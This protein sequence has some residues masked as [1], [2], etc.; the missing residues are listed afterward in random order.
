M[1]DDR[2]PKEI[3]YDERV[4]E[5]MRQ[6][7][8]I[9]KE[10]GISFITSFALDGELTCDTIVLEPDATP[11]LRLIATMLNA[12]IAGVFHGQPSGTAQEIGHA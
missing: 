4:H 11:K 7:I 2:G 8:E 3:A 6:I 9:C 5:L 1:G 12:R 10:H